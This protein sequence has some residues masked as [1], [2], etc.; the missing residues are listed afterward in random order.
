LTFI[1]DN[2]FLVAI[3]VGSGLMLV[4]P[5]FRQAGKPLGPVLATQFINREDAIVIDVREAREFEAGQLPGSRN[6]PFQ[7]LRA[8]A[9]ELEA[10]KEKPLL[11][12]CTSGV[13]A[14]Q[15]CAQLQRLGFTRLNTLEGGIDA[16]IRAGLPLKRS[17]K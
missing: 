14:G 5:G 13:R 11:L 12:V 1:Q 9:G 17:G 15:A 7:E 3:A 8:R 4:W 10:L 2:I 16:W 6:I